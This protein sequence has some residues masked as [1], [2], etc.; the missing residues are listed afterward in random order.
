MVV[1][2]GFIRFGLVL[3]KKRLNELKESEQRR[4][5]V[6]SCR[7]LLCCDVSP[8][9]HEAAELRV[10]QQKCFTDAPALALGKHLA[11]CNIVFGASWMPKASSLHQD[12]GRS[13]SDY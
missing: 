13:D 5:E 1:F 3:K 7:A 4:E 6:F 2:W 8:W 10:P 12:I 9:P 11:Q